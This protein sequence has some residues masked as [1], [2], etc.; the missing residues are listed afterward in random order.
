M[1][2]EF[3][4]E[5][6]LCSLFCINDEQREDADFDIKDICF[7]KFDISFGD[8]VHVALQLLPLTPIVKSPLSKTCYHAFI[9]N[10]TAFVKMKVGHDEN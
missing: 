9:H 10:G 7:D 4:Y 5:E 8:F 2:N 1:M 3:Y 6:L